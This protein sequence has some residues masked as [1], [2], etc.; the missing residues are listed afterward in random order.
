[1]PPETR[2]FRFGLI[3]DAGAASPGSQVEIAKRA[4]AVGVD[5]ALC[6]DHVGRWGMLGLLQAVAQA[7]SLRVGPFVANNDLRNPIVLA[8]E[9]ATLDHL[10]GGRVE[11]GLGAG[12]NRREYSATGITFDP[13]PVR[14]ARM[15]TAMSVIRGIL[16]DGS[17]AHAGDDTYG[18]MV[19]NDLP[20]AVQRPSPPFLVG[21]GRKKLLEF[22]AQ[23]A[24]TVGL[25]PRS[26][27][28]GTLDSRDV[29]ADSIDRKIGWIRQ[30]AG[31]RWDEL[32]IN[33]A[34]YAVDREL[35]TR[36]GPVPP[37]PH[38]VSEVEFAASPH[39]L[40]GDVAH[41]VETLQARRERWGISYIAIRTAHLHAMTEVVGRLAKT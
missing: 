25:N 7:T 37:R 17:V 4:E 39:Y 27:P 21:G 11:I 23:E 18:P 13:A 41:M 3:V 29:T 34:L 5:I 24:D 28:D 36:R 33:V 20:M 26:M 38:G 15:M 30:A 2:P 31:E 8:Q 9:I 16:R 6:T 12:W 40:G 10:S 19:A 14:V 32:E 22:A 35:H 1:M